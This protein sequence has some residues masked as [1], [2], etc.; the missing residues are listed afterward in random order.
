MCDSPILSL[1]HSPTRPRIFL[2][3]KC[4]M[5]W[6]WKEMEITTAAIINFVSKGMRNDQT[7]K[8]KNWRK[9]SCAEL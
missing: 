9:L 6:S 2:D 8:A 5:K 4:G 7:E 3:W 1:T